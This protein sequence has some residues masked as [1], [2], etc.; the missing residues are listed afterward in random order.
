MACEQSCVE[1]AARV[2]R[3][4]SQRASLPVTRR[5]PGQQGQGLRDFIKD[6]RS[7][8]RT[9]G[10]NDFTPKDVLKEYEI[11]KIKVA[12]KIEVPPVLDALSS[13]IPTPLVPSTI[14]R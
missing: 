3:T 2:G 13:L 8:E 5:Y 1:K 9:F 14:L 6:F 12:Y 10:R 4:V 7:G 11:N